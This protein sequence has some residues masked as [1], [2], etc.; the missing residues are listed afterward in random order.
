MREGKLCD[1]RMYDFSAGLYCGVMMPESVMKKLTKLN[2]VYALEIR[3]VLTDHKHE[4]YSSHWTLANKKDGEK[5]VKQVTIHYAMK[6]DNDVEDRI[7]LFTAPKPIYHK[8]FYIVE[9]Y[10][11]AKE[12]AE[13][14]L[15]E[16][17]AE[18]L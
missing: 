1:Q 7:S 8:D 4:L 10:E 14:I 3:K 6:K 17:L 15:Q 2:A 11:E 16:E 13:E 5:I 18:T 12:I 9:S